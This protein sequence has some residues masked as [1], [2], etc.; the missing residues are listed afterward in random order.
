MPRKSKKMGRPKGVIQMK[1]LTLSIPEE[2]WEKWKIHATKERTT[3]SELGVRLLTQYLSK[4]KG[5]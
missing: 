5:G 1:M 4:K 2:A 3:M